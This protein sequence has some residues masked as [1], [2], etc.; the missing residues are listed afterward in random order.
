VVR[1]RDRSSVRVRVRVR[2]RLRVRSEVK[3]TRGSA[4][5][6]CC[7]PACGSGQG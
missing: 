4:S 5:K 6:M 2:A 7:V 1:V 3:S